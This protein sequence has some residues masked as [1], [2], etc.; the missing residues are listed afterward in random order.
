MSKQPISRR[1]SRIKACEL[2]A[3]VMGDRP[4]DDLLPH[5]WSLAVFFENY[6]DCG[7]TATLKDFGPKKAVK[8]RIVRPKV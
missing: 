4:D 1:I 2:A 8:L 5:L 3:L 6:I 7:S